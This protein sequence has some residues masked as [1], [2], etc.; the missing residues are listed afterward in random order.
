MAD[1]FEEWEKAYPCRKARSMPPI[2]CRAAEP[3]T[4]YREAEAVMEF[5]QLEDEHGGFNIAEY[6]GMF[7]VVYGKDYVNGF[8]DFITENLS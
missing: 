4:T 3:C 7:Y 8:D 6:E 1:T 5:R 2:G